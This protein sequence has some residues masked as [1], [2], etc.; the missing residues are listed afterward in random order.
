MTAT[1]PYCR[2]PFEAAEEAVACPA[3]GTVH[4]AD[5]LADN[6]GCTVFGCSEAP[7]EEPKVSVSSQDMTRPAPVA[8]TPEEVRRP[9]PPPP[10][11]GGPLPPPPPGREFA[12]ARTNFVAGPPALG[13]SGYAPVTPPALYGYQYVARKNRVAFVL[14][15]IFFG[16]FGVHNFYAGYIKKAVIQC[17]LTVFTLFIASPLVWVWGIVEACTVDQ[18]DD[19]VKFS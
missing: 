11:M 9:V 16:A 8:A 17:C 14:L 13:F 4:H 3:C 15:A 5:C 18:D 1:C 2:S 10:R 12:P 7:V 19:G 6:Q